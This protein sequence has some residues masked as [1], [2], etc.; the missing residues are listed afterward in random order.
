MLKQSIISRNGKVTPFL[1]LIAYLI[2][3]TM[4]VEIAFCS[5]IKDHRVSKDMLDIRITLASV[6]LREFQKKGKTIMAKFDFSQ[7]PIA[8]N[9][10]KQ[11][12]LIEQVDCLRWT[13]NFS[14]KDAAVIL[15]E[16]LIQAKAGTTNNLVF[17]KRSEIAANHYHTV[18]SN[19]INVIAQMEADA[20]LGMS[21]GDVTRLFR[22]KYPSTDEKSPKKLE[23]NSTDPNT[24][25]V[26]LFR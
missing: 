4:Y 8:E 20:E 23:R 26:P 24:K 3:H 1:F 18:V 12:N 11:G 9:L 2:H 7:Y 6:A 5:E 21:I 14:R 10:L 19:E 15:A 16:M 17:K 13:G 22:H 25:V